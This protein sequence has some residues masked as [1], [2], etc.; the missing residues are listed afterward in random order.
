MR[1]ARQEQ[2]QQAVNAR[3][4]I[5]FSE[6]A[7]L[8]PQVS[9]MTLRTDL[10]TLDQEGRIVRIHGGARSLDTV[11][12]A[13]LPLRQRLGRHI[14]GK[15]EIARKAAPLVSAGSAVFLD[16]GS[17]MTELA[18]AFPNVECTVFCGGLSCIQEL[19]RLKKPEISILGGRL[20]KSSQ[21]VRDLRNL[22]EIQS[23]YF[24]VAFI[25]I[26]GFSPELG[27]FCQSSER[28]LMEQAVLGR[29]RRKV[30]LMDSSKVDVLST[31]LICPPDGVDTLVS[32]SLLPAHIKKQ[33][34]GMGVEVL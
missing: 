25:S 19:S 23:L 29:S 1:Q 6:L 27:F 13:D 7:D 21:S 12:G 14:E 34:T 8:F 28:Q 17:T 30:V 26:N 15:R 16:S 5:R 24:D 31:Y 4:F 3:G 2:I 10:K 18:R 33:L 32:D 11:R 22:L 20:N 9:E